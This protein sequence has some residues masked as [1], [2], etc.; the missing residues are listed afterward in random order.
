MLAELGVD[1]LERVEVEALT[2]VE[3]RLAE[4]QIL[5]DRLLLLVAPRR[6]TGRGD[7]SKQQQNSTEQRAR[8]HSPHPCRAETGLPA[9]LWSVYQLP[10]WMDSGPASVMPSSFGSTPLSNANVSVRLKSL[11]ESVLPFT[12][13]T[14]SCAPVVTLPV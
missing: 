8:A 11:S 12:D 9:T 3:Q 4:V 5:Q 6:R 7:R 10:S 1:T 14:I 2:R 13:T